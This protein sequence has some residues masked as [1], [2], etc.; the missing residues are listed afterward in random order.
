MLPAALAT[1]ANAPELD[2]RFWKKP[3]ITEE[4][5]KRLST[6]PSPRYSVWEGVNSGFMKWQEDDEEVLKKV[7]E[8]AEK[9]RRDAGS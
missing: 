9:A 4:T 6:L 2:N 5:I 7:K 8:K 1:K 3:V